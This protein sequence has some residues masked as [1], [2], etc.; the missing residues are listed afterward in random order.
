MIDT[1]TEY[2][3]QND[4][5]RLECKK[6]LVDIVGGPD[7]QYYAACHAIT[8]VMLA[9]ESSKRRCVIFHGLADTGKTY[10]NKME[11]IDG[12]KCLLYVNFS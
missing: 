7:T 10:I 12:V 11:N 5:P 6:D 4:I 2:I 1:L 8:D 9:G 3:N